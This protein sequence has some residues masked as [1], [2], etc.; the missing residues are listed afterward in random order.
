[1]S[2]HTKK[3][4]LAIVGLVILVGLFFGINQYFKQK[5]NTGDKQIVV[6][7]VDIDG[8]SK[9][10]Q[11]QTDAKYL[12]EVLKVEKLVKGEEGEYGLFITE[13]NGIAVDEKKQQWWCLTKNKEQVNTSADQTPISDGEQYE[14]TLTE[15]Y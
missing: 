2:K 14:L 7:I 5:V 9:D 6:T 13:A 11:C 3:L 15:G 4:V 1:M 10:F 12:G 8:D